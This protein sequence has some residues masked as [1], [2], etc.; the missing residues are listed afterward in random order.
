MVHEKNSRVSLCVRGLCH[1]RDFLWILAAI[2]ENRNTTGLSVLYRGFR[3]YF[4]FGFLV[5]LVINGSSRSIRSTCELDTGTGWESA[6]L[7]SSRARVSLF[8]VGEVD[9]LEE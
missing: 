6:R 3:F 7:R 4:G 1:P 2:P 9:E 8:V 5:G